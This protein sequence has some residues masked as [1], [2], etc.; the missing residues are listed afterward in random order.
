MISGS[1]SIMVEASRY[2]SVLP[3]DSVSMAATRFPRPS[4]TSSQSQT[5]PTCPK[6]HRLHPSAQSRGKACHTALPLLSSVSF[7]KGSPYFMTS[8]SAHSLRRRQVANSTCLPDQTP[9]VMVIHS[10]IGPVY[11][12]ATL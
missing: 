6:V 2:G 7:H 12:D 3:M 10:P 9:T 4:A 1:L 8:S 11:W 5:S